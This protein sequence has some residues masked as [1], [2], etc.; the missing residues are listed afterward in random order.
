MD[1]EQKKRCKTASKQKLQLRDMWPEKPQKA[2]KIDD[3]ML[4]RTI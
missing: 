1:S 4:L 3:K 2:T